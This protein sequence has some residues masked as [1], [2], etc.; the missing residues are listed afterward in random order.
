MDSFEVVI[1]ADI[2]MTETNK[3]AFVNGN[4]G[5][6]V[7][8]R[9]I[10]ILKGAD[11]R[12]FNLE[13]PL[14]DEPDPIDKNGPNL[15][16]STECI[17]GISELNPTLLTLANNHIMDQGCIGL[18]STLNCL[19]KANIP[20]V[21]VGE[22]ISEARKGQVAEMKGQRIGIY[23]CA[24]HEFSLASN[25]EPGANPF[26][27]FTSLDDITELKKK[28]DYLIVLYHGGKE[29]YRYPT[30]YLQ[31]VF[32]RMVDKGADLVIA[33]HSHCIGCEE[34]Y[35]DGILIYGQGNFIFDG[36][37]DEFWNSGMLVG[38]RFDDD[39]VKINYY[40]Y[41]KQGGKI[42]FDG[43][44]DTSSLMTD[45]QERS[46]Q[47]M[48][49]EFI[50]N[51]YK[52]YAKKYLETYLRILNGNS[53]WFRLVNKVSRGGLIYRIQKKRGLLKVLNLI[54][55]EAHRELILTGIKQRMENFSE[56]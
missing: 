49:E 13:G 9:I 41:R 30:P 12:I 3:D 33:Q 56:E 29:Y 26:D 18:N 46:E 51:N 45:Y 54:E 55:C 36:G 15:I 48:V 50:R 2:C 27:P 11:A 42:I 23:A 7:D 25:T 1:G 34:K 31:K 14:V 21:G 4:I 10:S 20:Y 24:E 17:K 32:R 44:S 22:S 8:Q 19:S 35:K 38:I 53:C 43:N 39:G 28:C 5:K 16:M 6:I 52:E 47:I 37:N 40:P